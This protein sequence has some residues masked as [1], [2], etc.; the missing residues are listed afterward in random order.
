MIS[1]LVCGAVDANFVDPMTKR[2]MSHKGE[3]GHELKTWPE[4]FRAIQS[5]AKAF[6]I[7][8]NDR[9]FQERDVL[10]LREWSQEAGYSGRTLRARVT[11]LVQGE[12]GLSPDICVMSL[13]VYLFRSD[14]IVD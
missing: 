6:E 11:Y 10:F 8:K 2:C 9:D 4:S 5:G 13:V 12:W 3:R 7:R 14:E 1:C